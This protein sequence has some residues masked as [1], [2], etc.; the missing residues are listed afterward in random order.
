MANRDLERMHNAV[1][2]GR[3]TLT[4]HAYDEMAQ[5]NLDVLDIE[6]AILTGA[7]EQALTMDPRGTRYAVVG[8]ATDQQTRRWRGLSF[9]RARSPFDHYR[10]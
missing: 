5:D 9:C 10:L 7:V 6:S 8:T 2:D 1:L 4:E 3:F